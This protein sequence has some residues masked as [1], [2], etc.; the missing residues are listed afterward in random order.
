M[1]R[2]LAKLL[3]RFS[4]RTLV[5]FM[6]LVTSGTGLWWRWGP[7]VPVRA[8]HEGPFLVE[9]AV[10]SPD[11]A[12]VLRADQCCGDFRLLDGITGANLVGRELDLSP[13]PENGAWTSRYLLAFSPDG[14]KVAAAE[15]WCDMTGRKL[16][17]RVTVWDV[18]TGE[19]LFV[20]DA[21]GKVLAAV[22]FSGDGEKLVVKQ[23]TFNGVFVYE[24]TGTEATPSVVH[25]WDIATGK[26][27][28]LLQGEA[29]EPYETCASPDGL[30]RVDVN[31]DGTAYIMRRAR[32]DAWWGIFYLWEFWLSAVFGALFIWSLWRDRRALASARQEDLG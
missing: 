10:Y 2:M 4:L 31:P 16:G 26:G 9:E 32:P 7:W 27:P 20:A 25:G 21:K 14:S 12:V 29:V 1:R 18:A 3:P 6:M 24:E 19:A 23:A 15:Q 13:D 22:N 30:R 17:P 28:T 8:L 11:G 5:L